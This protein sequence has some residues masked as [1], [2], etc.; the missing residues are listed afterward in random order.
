MTVTR[1][2]TGLTAAAAIAASL[3]ACDSSSEPTSSTT[4]TTSTTSTTSTTTTSSSTTTEA[5]SGV[6]EAE[7]TVLAFYEEMDQ[8]GQ[9]KLDINAVSTWTLIDMDGTDTKT[10][11]ST[12]LGEQVLGQKILQVGTTTVTGLTGEEVDKPASEVKFDAAYAVEACVDRSEL[13]YEKDGAPVDY[14]DGVATKTLVTHLV[15]DNKGA[16]RVVRDEPGASC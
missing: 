12:A 7:Q 6:D 4:T 15:I 10:K 5:A 2:L 1:T 13:T 8:L 16:Y 14:A 11:W 3:A 9:G